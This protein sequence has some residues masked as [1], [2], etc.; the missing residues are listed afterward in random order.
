MSRF[1]ATAP[2][3]CFI[4]AGVITM[5]AL[6]AFAAQAAAPAAG[7]ASTDW[8]Q[9]RGPDRTGISAETGWRTD[10]AANPPKVLWKKN[11]GVGFS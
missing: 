5:A 8:P 7:A 2:R 3:D 10:W 4:L 6:F 11:V 1:R 9:W